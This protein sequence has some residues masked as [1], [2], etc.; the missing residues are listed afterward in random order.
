[1]RNQ[2]R[3][4]TLKAASR[5]PTKRGELVGTHLFAGAEHHHGADL[6]A[7][8]RMG[9]ADH[10]AVGD[11]G[12]LEQRGFDL[13]AVDVLAAPDDHVLRPVHDVDEAFLVDPGHVAGMEP[14][15]GEGGGC[16][17]RAVPVAA[18]HVRALDP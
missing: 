8:H 2:K 18:H 17:G 4:G 9:H 11:G 1:M 15:A 5:S 16:L 14:S 6:F 10:R 7:E 3:E 13:D 12:V